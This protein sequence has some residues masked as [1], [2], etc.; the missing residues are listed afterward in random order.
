MFTFKEFLTESTMLIESKNLHLE[1]IEEEILNRGYE[2]GKAAINII[3]NVANMLAGNSDSKTLVTVKWD[4]S[5]AIVAGTNPENG[6]FFVGTKSVFNKRTPKLLYTTEDINELYGDKPDLANKLK[7]A[8]HY[9]SKLNISDR[10]LQGDIMFGPDDVQST[11]YEGKEY[12]TF[13][14]N[15][16]LYAVP[17]DSKLAKEIQR[18]KL[19]VIF[20]TEYHGDSIANL[21]GSFNVSLKGLAKTSDVWYDDATYLDASGSVTM[22]EQETETINQFVKDAKRALASID[23]K[24]FDTL[25]QHKHYVSL[26]K[27]YQNHLIR[28]GQAQPGSSMH[29]LAGLPKF[30]TQQIEKEKVSDATKAKKIEALHAH[31]EQVQHTLG[32]ILQFQVNIIQ[33]KHLLIEKLETA[34]QI[35]TFHVTDNGLKVA[36]Q[37]GFVAVDHIGNAVKLVDRLEFSR[38]NFARGEDEEVAAV[39]G[40]PPLQQQGSFMGGETGMAGK[41][42]DPTVG[43]VPYHGRATGQ[44]TDSTGTLG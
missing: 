7:N 33:A 22:T 40:T 26:L 27:R 14:P 39:I 12:I 44:F 17:A 32:K 4:G 11:T 20:H 25:F 23:R 19:G 2:G 37:E 15:T 21:R 9:L 3:E 16:V 1:H 24:E 30:L 6:K 36:K 31:T 38:Q 42:A 41:G 35:G 13:Q 34:K 5:P 8:L 43:D 18:A 10:I 28:G 29:W